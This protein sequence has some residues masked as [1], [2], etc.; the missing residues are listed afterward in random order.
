[1]LKKEGDLVY[2]T[3]RYI[4]LN[5]VQEW[6]KLKNRWLLTLEGHDLQSTWHAFIW[7]ERHTVHQYFQRH[8]VRHALLKV[9]IKTKQQNYIKTPVWLSTLEAIVHP[10]FMNLGKIITYKD[11]DGKGGLKF[12]HELKEEGIQLEWWAYLKIQSRY[13]KYKKEWD[14]QRELM[15]LDK[16]LLGTEGKTIKIIYNYLLEY[17]MEEEQVKEVM[18]KW[19]QNFGYKI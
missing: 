19:A 16:I 5:W 3:G 8:Y 15:A 12:R 18:I 6:I 11:L 4:T 14:I 13:K 9:S 7:D 17:K 10:N 2:L 1:M